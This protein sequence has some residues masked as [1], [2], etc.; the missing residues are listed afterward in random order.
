MGMRENQW[1][2]GTPHTGDWGLTGDTLEDT[3]TRTVISC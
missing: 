1:E 3:V 2:T